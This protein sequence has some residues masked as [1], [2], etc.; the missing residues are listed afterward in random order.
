MND[1]DVQKL[2]QA[3][4]TDAEIQDYQQRRQAPVAGRPAE[5]DLPSVDPNQ[6]SEV[7]AAARAQG[8]PTESQTSNFYNDLTTVL[9]VMASQ[10]AGP[11]AATLGGGAALLGANQLRKG[12]QS[13]A[14]AS[15]AQA[16]AQQ[17]QAQAMM[18]QARASQM[19]SQGLQERFAQRQAAQAA[20]AAT[21][22]QLVSAAGQPL[23]MSPGPVTPQPAPMATAQPAPTQPSIVQRGMDIA[24]KM[25]ELAASRA[26]QGAM[27]MGAGM[28]AAVTPG[29]VGQRYNFPTSGPYAGME[30]NPNTRRPWTPE[31][32][33]KLGQ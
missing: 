4:F 27:K 24:A 29:N 20:R 6:P 19:A 31:E 2:R 17:A 33:A 22:P 32:L 30:I 3:G 15:T 18:E 28:A 9:P 7:L 21:T 26:M 1:Q 5:S 16:A 14:A 8:I 23:S 10:Y 11:I 12:M 13:R 25:R